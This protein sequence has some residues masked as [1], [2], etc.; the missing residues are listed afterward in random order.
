MIKAL[1]LFVCVSQIMAIDP[2]GDAISQYIKNMGDSN[3][4]KETRFITKEQSQKYENFFQRIVARSLFERKKSVSMDVLKSYKTAYL[5]K[6]IFKVYGTSFGKPGNKGESNVFKDGSK[7][8]WGVLAAALP[9]NSAVG[10]KIQVRRILANGKKTRWITVPVKDLG[11][12]FRDDPYWIKKREPRAVHYFRKKMKRWDGRVVK[13]PAGIDLT[14]WV[15]QKLG[16]SRKQSLNHS[17][18]VEWRFTH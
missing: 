7:V 12:W 14:P 8:R 11:P 3:T 4:G 9:D 13:N 5:G 15:W 1:F 18:Y 16:V 2:V 10:S 17:G 6:G